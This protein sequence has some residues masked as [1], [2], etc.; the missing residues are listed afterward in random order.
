MEKKFWKNF[1][2]KGKYPP[3]ISENVKKKLG[4]KSEFG[5]L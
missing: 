5:G 4:K 2:E 3:Y 1:W